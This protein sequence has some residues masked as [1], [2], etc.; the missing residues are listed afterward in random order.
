MN[1]HSNALVAAADLLQQSS[2]LDLQD[3]DQEQIVH[4]LAVFDFKVSE[5][6]ARLAELRTRE[7]LAVTCPNSDQ[8]SNRTDTRRHT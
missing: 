7:L 1:D 4:M 6:E 2:H 8:A 5:I 3:L